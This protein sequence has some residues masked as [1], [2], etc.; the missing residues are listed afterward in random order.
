MIFMYFIF[1]IGRSVCSDK[2]VVVIVTYA[3]EA[4]NVYPLKGANKLNY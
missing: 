4:Q 2:T 3:N 1:G